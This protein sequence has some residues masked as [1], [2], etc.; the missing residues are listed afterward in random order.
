MSQALLPA[1]TGGPRL[2]G[3][4]PRRWRFVRLR[5]F[6]PK[7]A[8]QP[9]RRIVRRLPGANSRGRHPLQNAGAASRARFHGPAGIQPEANPA[10][11]RRSP[12]ESVRVARTPRHSTNRSLRGQRWNRRCEYLAHRCQRSFPFAL[13]STVGFLLR[14]FLAQADWP[15][16]RFR[17]RCVNLAKARN[18]LTSRAI[19]LPE[20]SWN[21][22]W[23]QLRGGS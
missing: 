21:F 22:P 15:S 20:A 13:E 18:P 1:W 14:C 12:S 6:R 2:P 23:S 17:G 11:G 7:P 8:P 4:R 9:H 16:R 19:S 10:A 3:L 5:C